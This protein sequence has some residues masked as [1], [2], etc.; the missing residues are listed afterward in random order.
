AVLAAT[1][2]AL[3]D[4]WVWLVKNSLGWGTVSSWGEWWNVATP[5]DSMTSLLL[6]WDN[7]WNPTN[8]IDSSTAWRT[9]SFLWNITQQWPSKF[10][11]SSLNFDWVWDYLTIPASNDFVFWTWDFTIDFWVY[12]NAAI[13]RPIISN[14]PNWAWSTAMWSVEY[15]TIANRVEF[16]DW[17][18]QVLIS[19]TSVPNNTWSHVAVVRSSWTLTIYL[20]W[21][22]IWSVAN[23]ANYSANNM[24]YI[25]NDVLPLSDLSWQ[26][27]LWSIDELRVSKW[28][29]RWTSNFTPPITAY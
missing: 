13:R 28:I 18:T 11:A 19:N 26:Q 8:F 2:N 12:S 27:F 25:W 17:T 29:A 23:S 4:L 10:W 1:W 24:I 20:N 9:M 7:I 6:H 21:S 15:Y 5:Q 3:T 14:R 22:A 16:H